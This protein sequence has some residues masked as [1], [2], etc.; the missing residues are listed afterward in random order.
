MTTPEMKWPS[1]LVIVRHGESERNVAKASAA[2]AGAAEFGTGIRDNDV[3]LT[4]HGKEQARSTGKHLGRRFHFDRVFASP[5]LR[6]WETARLMKE[7]F[8]YAVDIN[9]EERAREIEFGILDGL[10]RSGMK[11]RYPLE[12]ARR[13]KMGKYWYRAPGGENYPDIALRLHSLLGTLSR[14]YAGRSVLV[15]CHSVVVLIFRRLLERLTE[16]ELMAI[17]RD[18]KQEVAN[19]GVTHYACDAGQGRR[20][21]LVLKEFNGVYYS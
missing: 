13:E 5:Y 18:P 9:W 19:C 17:D 8:P 6:A 4:P 2:A 7:Q 12:H 10:T 14:D 15:V 16:P 3:P 21:R 20:G 11:A 1:H